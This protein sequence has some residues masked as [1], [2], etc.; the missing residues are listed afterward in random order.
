MGGSNAFY[1]M[2]S[3]MLSDS[4]HM[5]V[6]NMALFA[7]VGLDFM[8]KELRGNIKKNDVVVLSI[9]YFLFLECRAK[10]EIV[11][12]Y[13]QGKKY[14]GIDSAS[15][16]EGI[17]RLNKFKEQA[18]AI[19]AK[20]YFIFPPLPVSEYKKYH[21]IIDHYYTDF[22]SDLKIPMLCDPGAMLFD[23]NLFYD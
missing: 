23:D 21:T 12:Y 19:G 3:A 6:V 20:V 22:R 4:I 17:Q 16:Y 5:N 2:N 13:P 14:M 10:E 9:E 8:L 1:G 7:G 11:R 15:F 18:E